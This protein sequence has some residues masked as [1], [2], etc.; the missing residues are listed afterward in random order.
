MIQMNEKELLGAN[1][2]SNNPTPRT[3]VALCL[4]ISGSMSGQPIQALNLGIE[5]LYESIRNDKKA[6]LSADL[7]IITFES[8]VR[9]HEAFSSIEQKKAPKLTAQNGTALGHGLEMAL[10]L[11]IERKKEYQ[12]YGT[13]YHQPMIFLLTDGL[14]GDLNKLREILPQIH[15][16]E[17]QKKLVVFPIGVGKDV[18]MRL[19]N[20]ISIINK[21]LHISTISFDKLFIWL[22]Q[23]I[24]S[25][26][27]SSVGSETTESV[28]IE[29]MKSTWKKLLT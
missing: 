7:A 22:S 6:R 5:T 25:V 27:Q 8:E 16:L 26:S 24:R 20:E 1:D 9:L 29:Q 19:M 2:L 3:P 18:D 12:Q 28:N 23:S 10:N 11:V 4:D 21:N 13:E 14:P 17:K 15:N